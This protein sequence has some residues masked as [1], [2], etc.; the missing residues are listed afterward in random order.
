MA[1]G[2]RRRAEPR[3]LDAEAATDIEP[4]SYSARIVRTIDDGVSRLEII[5][6]IARSGALRREEWSD[7]GRARALI[8]RPD[9]GKAF[10]LDLDSQAYVETVIAPA[11]AAEPETNSSNAN[12]SRSNSRPP[13]NNS[14]IT[15]AR[16]GEPD[17]P[18]AINPSD[19]ERIVSDAPLPSSVETIALADQTIENHL[20]KVFERRASFPGGHI[21]ITRVFRALDLQGFA[22]RI[23]SESEGGVKI[24]TERR[25]AQ[26]VVSPDE[27]IIPSNFKKVG[28]L[29]N[30]QSKRRR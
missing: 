14:S 17:S 21:E 16:E 28:R 8:S 7:Q 2:C 27:F 26:T 6:R 22:I 13:S 1:F 11:G 3:N 4:E 19:I 15:N 20:C 18:P 9:L 10:L 5:T 12:K 30:E 23:E 25:D 24:I 29:D